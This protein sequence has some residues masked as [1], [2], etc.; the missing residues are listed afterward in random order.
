MQLIKPSCLTTY[1]NS[2]RDKNRTV[3]FDVPLLQSR[4]NDTTEIRQHIVSIN[5]DERRRFGNSKSGLWYQKKK[6]TEGESIK[7]YR[8]VAEKIL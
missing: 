8:K 2:V 3:S 4:K 6:L 5:P 7:F 1:E